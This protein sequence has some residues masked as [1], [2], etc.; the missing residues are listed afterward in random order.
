MKISAPAVVLVAY[1]VS[2]S[3]AYALTLDQ[4]NC[5]PG[6]GNCKVTISVGSTC[7]A[8]ITVN[9]EPITVKANMAAVDIQWEIVT[10]GW[11]FDTKGIYLNSPPAGEFSKEF[12]AGTKTYGWNDAAKTKATI[13]YDVNLRREKGE[14]RC[15]LDPTIMNY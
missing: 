14:E 7:G 5:K 15:K 8:G 9:P 13:K 1:A 4:P 6:P 2:I 10:P 11:V 3:A 12:G